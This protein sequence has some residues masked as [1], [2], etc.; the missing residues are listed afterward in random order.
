[1][2]PTRFR[3]AFDSFAQ[4]LPDREREQRLLRL[5]PFLDSG[6]PDRHREDWKYTDL[7]AFNDKAYTPAETAEVALDA[8]RLPRTD[9][10]VY[11]NGHLDASQSSADELSALV[12]DESS[13]IDSIAALNA[14]F[15]LPGLNLRL[16]RNA[17][18][19]RVLH[20]IVVTTPSATPA[21]SHQRHLIELGELAHA[22]VVFEF[23]GAG[24]HLQT[25]SL[26]LRLGTGSRLKLDRV[27]VSSSGSTLL[28]RI[29]ARLDRDSQLDARCIDGG[30]GLTRHDFN[31]DLAGVNAEA[32]LNG[33]YLPAAGGHIDN[34]TCIVH[35][36]PHC[37]SRESFRG[38]VDVRARA[39][40]NGKVVVRPGA[41]KTDSEQH[42]ANLLLSPRAEVNAKPELEIY[43]DDVKCAH[44][45]TVG[46]LDLKALAYLRSRGV[47]GETAR[48]MLLRAFAAEILDGITLPA[49]NARL[50]RDL[51]FPAETPIEEIA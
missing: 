35:S 11:V 40:F 49:L 47:D 3:S 16:G 30:S 24:D 32:R 41:Q 5:R 34:H 19:A 14:A 37:R 4:Q 20:I 33:L 43:A 15:A 42:V 45:A 31:I 21:M 29:D 26:D 25:H 13:A 39:V 12:P 8:L 51:G 2:G 48:A 7:A 38:I 36:A 9:R 18:I 27:Q 6:F 10:L 22:H 28:T 1:M 50:A 46:Q 23:R 17:S 44:G